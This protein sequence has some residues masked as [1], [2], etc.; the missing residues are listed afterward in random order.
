MIK[1]NKK[2]VFVFFVISLFLIG[3]GISEIIS[4]RNGIENSKLKDYAILIPY[5]ISAGIFFWF[6]YI[7]KDRQIV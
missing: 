2:L 5:C 4:E 3:I 6:I 7:K 1:L